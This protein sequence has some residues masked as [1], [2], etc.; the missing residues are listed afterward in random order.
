[1]ANQ[2][3]LKLLARYPRRVQPLS[4]FEPQGNAGGYSGAR[5]W[6]FRAPAGEFV[7]RS[8]PPQGP[9]RTQLEK[10]HHW[11]FLTSETGLAPLPVRDNSDQ[12]LQEFEG[13]L[14]EITPWLSGQAES[15]HPP[16]SGRVE[17]AFAGLAALHARW[18]SIT[19]FNT[20][21]GLSQRYGMVGH[22]IRLGFD[23]IEN[24]IAKEP[25]SSMLAA[26]GRQWLALARSVAPMLHRALRFPSKTMVHLQ[27]CLR[28]A[29]PEHFLFE[30]DRLSGIVDF[31]AMGMECVAGDLARLI[32]EWLGGD[33][34][35][36]AQALTAYERIRPLAPWETSLIPV[37]ESSADLLIGER[38]LHW[39]FLEGRQF[40]DPQAV[41]KGLARGLKRLERLALK[42]PRA[43]ES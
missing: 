13:T 35:L 16:P 19:E 9:S 5:L 24:A 2:D 26:A 15:A 6:R 27:P 37:F 14:W 11:L 8:W 21:L 7:L 31:G 25:A 30:Q 43:L 38:W 1:M 33:P 10:I 20:S 4:D 42:M 39:H 34:A 22:L 36:R 29:R 40:D 28:D 23:H 41:S 18:V 17:A 3:F 12:T 32:G